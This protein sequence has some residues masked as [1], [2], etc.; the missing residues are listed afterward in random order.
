MK[1]AVAGHDCN[2]GRIAM[3]LGKCGV[4]FDQRDVAIDIMGIPVCRDGFTVPFDEAEASR[5][6]EAPE[7]AI[8]ADLGAGEGE[9]TVWTCDL[10]HE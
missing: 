4:T 5:R 8:W 3:V 9:A 1:T 7:I 2:W 6:F 10:T